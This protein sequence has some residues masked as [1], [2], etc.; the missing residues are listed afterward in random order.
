MDNINRSYM[1]AV[2]VGEDFR[3][4]LPDFLKS[5]FT[6]KYVYISAIERMELPLLLMETPWERRRLFL[7]TACVCLRCKS[8]FHHLGWFC[9]LCKY[10]SMKCLSFVFILMVPRVFWPS[11]WQKMLYNVLWNIYPNHIGWS[12]T[13]SWAQ[14]Q[15]IGRQYCSPS[16]P[17]NN[18][19]S[20]V[21]PRIF[22]NQF[23]ACI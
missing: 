12:L 4:V 9:G 17:P 13:H 8:N 18:S 20:V 5:L 1:T 7:Q 6:A 14:K 15:I 3:S 11:F 23:L 21:Y 10:L 16:T 22:F 19:A 2:L